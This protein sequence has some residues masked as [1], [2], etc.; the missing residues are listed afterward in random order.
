[1]RRL[2]NRPCAIHATL[3]ELAANAFVMNRSHNASNTVHTAKN[4]HPHLAQTISQ[5]ALVKPDESAVRSRN[6]PRTPGGNI[7][8]PVLFG[9]P[10]VAFWQQFSRAFHA[11]PLKSKPNPLKSKMRTPQL[12]LLCYVFHDVWR[13]VA[14]RL[15]LLWPCR[16]ASMP[17]KFRPKFDKIVELLLYLAHVRPGADKYQAVKFFYLADR[18]HLRRYGRPITFENYYALDYGP[19]AS[20]ALDLLERDPV[21]FRQ[22]RIKNL[23]FETE[24]GKLKNGRETVYIRKP[25]REVNRDLFSKSDL[26][27]FD[28]VI[29]KYRDATFDDLYNL[30]HKHF[31]YT[32]A[33]NKRRFGQK[34][35]EMHYDEMIDDEARKKA[36]ME[37]IAPV[38]EHM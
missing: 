4:L 31:A 26:R 18:E 17:L 8:F 28:E 15:R 21:T 23:P 36:L 19:V 24:V 38:A 2:Y 14:N 32:E 20:N 25:L 29:A 9:S 6:V 3:I 5:Y 27:V 16:E 7:R 34:R 11:Q 1:M 37:D 12:G 30:T 35:A 13:G 22:A 33:W 10:D